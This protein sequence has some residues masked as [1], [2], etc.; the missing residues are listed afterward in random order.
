[1]L[2]FQIY[3]EDSP[4]KKLIVIYNDIKPDNFQE[5]TGA[6]VEGKFNPDGTFHAQNL[7]LKCPSK[8]EQADLTQPDGKISRFLKALGLK[9]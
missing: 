5:A 1:M 7:N 3:D 6:V 9:K 2:K 4:D 8:Y